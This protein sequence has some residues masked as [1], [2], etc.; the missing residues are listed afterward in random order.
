MLLERTICI[1]MI[2]I[3][4]VVIYKPLKIMNTMR[5]LF[6]LKEVEADDF[7]VLMYRTTG[8]VGFIAFSL[9]FLQTFA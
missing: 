1:F 4:M 5:T 2:I 3:S 8:I 6:I 9:F 7:K